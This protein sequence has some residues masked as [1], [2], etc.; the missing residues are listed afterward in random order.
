MLGIYVPVN[1]GEEDELIASSG[2]LT[3]KTGQ[4]RQSGVGLGLSESATGEYLPLRE[5]T[6]FYGRGTASGC[7][8]GNRGENCTW[9]AGVSSCG[10]R[11]QLL[12]GAKEEEKLVLDNGAAYAA[13]KLVALVLRKKGNRGE[14]SIYKLFFEGER[15]D[16]TPVAAAK[17]PES[18]AVNLVGAAF[19]YSV[20]DATSGAAI[21]RR[22]V[23][24]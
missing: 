23:R 7:R 21:L 9:C 1:L 16:R 22:V 2:D 12:V 19:R 6:E 20:D 3:G 24:C 8:H 18:L 17:E 5:S 15:V 13:A 10:E 11:T 4:E 14:D